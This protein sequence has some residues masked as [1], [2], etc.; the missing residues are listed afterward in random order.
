VDLVQS[1]LKED[2]LKPVTAINTTV[3]TVPYNNTEEFKRDPCCNLQAGWDGDCCA[4]KTIRTK[5]ESYVLDHKEIDQTCEDT[6]CVDSYTSDFV[7]EQRKL[8]RSV[9]GCDDPSRTFLKFLDV[10]YAPYINCRDSIFGVNHT[11]GLNCEVDSDCID[12]KCNLLT[13]YCL[14]DIEKQ[15]KRFVDCL[16][17][18]LNP[19]ILG[20]LKLKYSID[21]DDPNSDQFKS[22]LRKGWTNKDCVGKY[23]LGLPYRNSYY[24]G[25]TYAYFP[26][27]GPCPYFF[28]IDPLPTYPFAC[29]ASSLY[30]VYTWV[31][32]LVSFLAICRT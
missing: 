10:E 9:L 2:G 14:N 22:A 17:Q 5:E 7:L 20:Y 19:Y 21:S 18:N 6:Q 4:P 25:P 3:C 15:E 1:L 23:E 29:A 28:D 26:C 32:R 13:G 8:K 24:W 31:N 30:C 16:A 11:L 27:D 12:S